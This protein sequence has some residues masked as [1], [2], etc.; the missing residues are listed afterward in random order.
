MSL[1]VYLCI[2]AICHSKICYRPKADGER[3]ITAK[4]PLKARNAIIALPGEIGI[5]WMLPTEIVSQL[6][7]KYKLAFLFLL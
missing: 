4:L 3:D 1:V 5:S 2:A 7:E 6:E